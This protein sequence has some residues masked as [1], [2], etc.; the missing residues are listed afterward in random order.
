M[1]VFRD[2]SE[3]GVGH[4]NSA[5]RART[6]GDKNPAPFAAAERA[7]RQSG[8]CSGGRCFWFFRPSRILHYVREF[9]GIRAALRR[10]RLFGES[11]RVFFARFNVTK[12]PRRWDTFPLPGHRFRDLARALAS[13]A[14]HGLVGLDFHD[15]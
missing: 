11:R 7:I 13:Y 12:H 9:L 10:R 2:S 6:R 3:I 5:I 4:C 1:P 8:L 14:H 15:S